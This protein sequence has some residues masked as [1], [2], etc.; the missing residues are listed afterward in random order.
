MV[1]KIYEMVLTDRR[2]KVREIVEATGISNG[3]VFRILSE[4]SCMKKLFA[5]R[6][7]RLLIPD[8]ITRAQLQP[9]QRF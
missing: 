6:M 7:P 3:N 2:L 8:L 4:V 9:Q 1:E 5:R